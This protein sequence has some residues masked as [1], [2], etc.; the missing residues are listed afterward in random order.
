MFPFDPSNISAGLACVAALAVI[1]FIGWLIW[2]K[3]SGKV[4]DETEDEFEEQYQERKCLN[5]GYDMRASIAR[6]PECGTKFIDRHRYLHSLANDWPANPIAPRVPAPEEQPVLLWST[7]DG[8]E[9]DLLQKQLLARGIACSVRWVPTRH[10]FQNPEL[11]GGGRSVVA[12]SWNDVMVYTQDLELAKAYL[13]RV[14][15]TEDTE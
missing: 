14:Q 3:R 1:G 5:C 13:R 8:M 12:E 9:A 11:Y 6:C 4:R 2:A 10:R 7:R 15:V